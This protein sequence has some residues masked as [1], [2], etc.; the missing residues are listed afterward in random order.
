M[1]QEESL[2]LWKQHFENLL[3]KPPSINEAV[4]TPLFENELSIKKGAFTMDELCTVQKNTKNGKSCG[5]DIFVPQHSLCS[6]FS[7]VRPHNGSFEGKQCHRSFGW[8]QYNGN[9]DS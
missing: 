3:G 4:I 6:T 5:L 9:S 8:C 2:K 1:S 7:L